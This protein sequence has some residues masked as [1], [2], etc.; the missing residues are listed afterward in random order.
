MDHH[1]GKCSTALKTQLA[2]KSF[3]LQIFCLGWKMQHQ[4]VCGEGRRMRAHAL[5]SRA[6]SCC[7]SLFAHRHPPLPWPRRGAAASCHGG[8]Q[9]SAGRAPRELSSQAIGPTVLSD[10]LP[11]P[12]NHG[13]E[14][15]PQ[16]GFSTTASCV[17]T[18]GRRSE[19][20][21]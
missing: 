4:D 5:F 13:L 2:A 15:K 7:P 20:S 16:S 9:H 11:P 21:L 19:V 1:A 12:V 14:A 8:P 18:P 17:V 10:C 6:E 3:F